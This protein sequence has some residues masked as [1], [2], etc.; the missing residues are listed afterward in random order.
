MPITHGAMAVVGEARLRRETCIVTSP[1]VDRRGG[2]A[3]LPAM[4]KPRKVKE[5]TASYT[6]A[7]A[8]RATPCLIGHN[9]KLKYDAGSR[10]NERCAV[11]ETIDKTR[12]KI[13]RNTA[14][15]R[16]SKLGQFLTPAVTAEFMAGLFTNTR[17]KECRLL[18]AGAGIG[19]LT[20]A[21]LERCAVGNMSFERIKVEAF[22]IDELLL[23]ELQRS[24]SGFT[25]SLP[26]EYIINSTDFIDE[27][28]RRIIY[29]RGQ[30]FTHAILNPPYKKIGNASR[31]RGLLRDVKIETVNLYSAFVALTVALLEK[32]GQLVAIIPR[33]FCNGPYYRP[34][35]DYLRRTTAI[36]RIHLF[37]S[38]SKA[39]KDDEVLQENII[40]LLEAGAEQGDV[41][42]S[43]S[44]DTSF[45]DFSTYS[46][47][48]SRIV[49]P[50]D[51]ERC[52]HVPALG[53]EV[54]EK[55]A[56]F[57]HSLEE[58]SINI[59][60]GPVVDFRL[61]DYLRDM[62]GPGTI[63]LLYPGHFSGEH[64]EWPKQGLKKPNAIQRNSATEKW[65]YPNGFYC[66]VRRFS[67]KEERRRIVASVVPP[68]IFAGASVLGFEN[69]LNVFHERKHGLPEA[70]A[71]GL[72]RYLITTAVDRSF[73][74]FNGHTQVNATDLKIMKYPS[75]AVLMALG[76][77]ALGCQNNQHAVD[78]LV[79]EVTGE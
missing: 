37:D 26:L 15:S 67:A 48:F 39:F 32:G 71:R 23:P 63:P 30:S 41:V 44:T 43:H 16:K 11:L 2:S 34:F 74:S 45:N 73:R 58:L 53:N 76:E 29:R 18:D 66:V 40:I 46:H 70:L 56:V 7:P 78:D 14:A 79:K 3:T 47:P 21:F 72:A 35:R 25:Q 55:S 54:I 62:P 60:T 17:I 65:L 51:P 59:S 68:D 9:D 49:L 27:A 4:P 24:I 12:L 57:T 50:E 61:K 38:R 10:R 42:V 33:S 77:K 20:C 36:R 69:H 75:R 22:E 5:E 31:Y 52:I 64:L 6:A 1:R 13:S 8:A 28:T 19:S